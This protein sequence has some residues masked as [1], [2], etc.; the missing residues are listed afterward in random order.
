MGCLHKPFAFTCHVLANLWTKKKKTADLTLRPLGAC[1]IFADC[2]YTFSVWVVHVLK[3]DIF[4]WHPRLHHLAKHLV[5]DTVWDVHIGYQTPNYIRTIETVT[6]HLDLTWN[7]KINVFSAHLCIPWSVCEGGRP[8]NTSQQNSH[9]FVMIF[10]KN[11][12]P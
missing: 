5:T 1:E 9:K 6:L 8:H 10:K 11:A 7:K 3:S 2:Q 12:L 4:L